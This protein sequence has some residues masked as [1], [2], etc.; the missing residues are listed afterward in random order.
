MVACEF[1]Y[2]FASGISV[3]KYAKAKSPEPRIVEATIILTNHFI[4]KGYLVF[5]F[6]GGF[7]STPSPRRYDADR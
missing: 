1:T 6:R 2:S 4:Y 7:R 5:T 3:L